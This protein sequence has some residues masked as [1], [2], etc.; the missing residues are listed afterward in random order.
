MDE[1]NVFCL[2]KGKKFYSRSWSRDR[3]FLEDQVLQLYRVAAGGYKAAI[4][5]SG[6]NAIWTVMAS[7]LLPYAA[8]AS[9]IIVYGSELY[10]DVP[11]TVKLLC[12]MNPGRVEAEAVDVRDSNAL[13]RL[14]TRCGKNIRIFH[15]EACTNP[16][17]QM[18]DWDL[19]PELR[20]LAPQCKFV[21]DNTWLSGG[22]GFNPLLLGADLVVESLTKHLSGGE[23]IGGMALG[24]E[25]VMK[26]V[27]SYVVIMGLFIPADRCR[28][29]AKAVARCRERVARTSQTALK[30]AQKLE[31]D[32][33]VG[34]VMFPLLPSHPTHSINVRVLESCTG[35]GSVWFFV[36]VQ[37]Q[38][39]VKILERR[40]KAPLEYKTSFGG[41]N[42]SLDPWP[43]ALP[44][45]AYDMPQ[46]S[47]AAAGGGSRKGTWLRLSTGYCEAESVTLQ[48]VDEM[49]EQLLGP[50]PAAV[51][52]SQSGDRKGITQTAT[53]AVQ[54]STSNSGGGVSTGAA[55]S[56]GAESVHGGASQA[57]GSSR[58][59]NQKVRRW[60]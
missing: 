32:P 37:K 16:S 8:E 54:G 51:G 57:Q 47:S 55:A 4:F 59:P 28:T 31:A 46:E 5:S 41:P 7:H 19:I 50:A 13:R 26:P 45:H 38:E 29:F 48:A 17:G 58:V 23:C 30:V 21:C 2:K 56:V 15:F 36:P 1:S 43:K 9:S 42:S 39:A 40:E 20:R 49:L 35:P 14:F 11:R 24:K 12:D 52:V 6:M 25:E 60:G 53:P 34:R 22:S 10:C 18:M 44:E 27:I 3:G 33:R